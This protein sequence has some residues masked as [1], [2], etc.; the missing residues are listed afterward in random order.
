MV[1][2]LLATVAAR[3][4]ATAADDLPA[5]VAADLQATVGAAAADMVV[6]TEQQPSN[7]ASTVATVEVSSKT[8]A[9][10]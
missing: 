10:Y 4:L 6:A 9:Y 2:D 7:T 8:S 3:L 1:P 5:M